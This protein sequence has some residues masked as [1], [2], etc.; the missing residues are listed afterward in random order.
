[1]KITTVI[2]Q[3]SIQIKKQKRKYHEHETTH[4]I[5]VQMLRCRTNHMPYRVIYIRLLPI[6][7]ISADEV[8]RFQAA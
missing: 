2:I 3:S 4:P 1:M 7:L 8:I 5:L 6:R